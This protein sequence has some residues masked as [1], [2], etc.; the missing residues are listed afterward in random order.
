MVF[1]SDWKKSLS[2]CGYVVADRN[3]VDHD[4]GFTG[5]D[6]GE[7]GI[8]DIAT[9]GNCGARGEYEGR[10]GGSGRNWIFD[11]R[12]AVAFH[13]AH[14]LRRRRALCERILEQDSWGLFR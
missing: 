14:D 7:T 3:R 11:H 10:I 12:A 13:A 1:R 2:D 9:A 4:F 5:G 6:A 8:G